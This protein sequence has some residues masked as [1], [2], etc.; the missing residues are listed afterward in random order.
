MKARIS[1]GLLL[2]LVLASSASLHAQYFG[3]Q[4]MEKSFEQTD[5]FFTPYQLIPFGIGTFKNSVQG[6]LD[7]PQIQLAVNPAYLYHDSARASYVY[8]DFRSAREIRETNDWY[9][10]YPLLA[11]KTALSSMMPYPR[12]YINT[13]R[14][15]EPVVSA[16]YLFR[17]TEG[18]LSNLSLGISYQMIAQDEK[19]YSIPQDIY[20]SVLGANYL[21]VTS[22]AAENIPIVDKYSGAD[23]MHQNGHFVALFAGYEFA[24]A[25]QVGAKLGR[26]TFDRDGSY[27]S[28]NLWDSY[29][30]T[31]NTSLWRNSEGRDQKYRHWELIG[32]ANYTFDAKYSI[33]LTGGYLWGDAD[34]TL[35]RGD[36][37]YYGYGQIGSTT[38][39]WNFWNHSAN[40][41]QSW[42]H[43]G[44][45]YL[46]GINLK[47]QVNPAQLF[48]FHYLYTR[49]NTDLLLA[50]DIIDSSYGMSRYRYDTTISNH[51]SR[52]AL[53]DRRTGTGT[54]VGD[55]H[56]AVGSLQWQITPRVKLSI[57]LQFESRIV[58]TKTNE[59]VVA[60]RYSRYASTGTYPHNYFDSTAEAKSL[61]WDFRSKSTRFSIP[62]FF[63]IRTS[64]VVELL[65]G[66]NRSAANWQVDD[67]TLAIFDYRVQLGQQ[68]LTRKENFGER[69]T[70]PQERESD[71]RTTLLAGLTVSPSNA[72]NV[73]FLLVPNFV[74][75]YDGSELSEFQWWIS[76][77]LRP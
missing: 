31:D 30:S 57:G 39:N 56:R 34:Q 71:V 66:L 75:T 72:F 69:Y 35:T 27:G 9:Y 42:A 38:Q 54:S 74:D 48:Q 11:T 67:V 29:Y 7:D 36:S 33:G 8:L 14:E 70:Q 20:K 62:I 55:I 44:K 24:P 16:T 51:T 59:A 19:Y 4:V 77:N 52:Y 68:G 10:P 3:E 63:T 5:F 37:S 17:P 15:L 45:T 18:A 28:Q 25:F 73:R 21:G 1:V 50:G 60:K 2:C 41:R 53:F 64:D 23:N 43:D 40:Q 76:V 49:Q 65:F 46:G 32:G 12:Y 58:E 6:V 61:Q 47:A 26:V 22:K 13:R